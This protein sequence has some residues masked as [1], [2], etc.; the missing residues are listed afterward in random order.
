MP[1]ATFWLSGRGLLS[2]ANAEPET[3]SDVQEADAP[4]I[5]DTSVHVHEWPFR[6]LKYSRTPTLVAKL[7]NHRIQQAWTG[8]FEALLHKNLNEV[9]ARLVEQCRNHGEG[10]LVPFGS[11]NPAWPDWEE[12][13]RR[14]HE[15]YQMPGIRLYPSYHGYTF[16]HRNFTKLIR[17][18]AE[19]GLL[20]QIVLKMEDDRVHHT[21]MDILPLKIQPLIVVLEEIPLA[22][23]Q[24]INCDTALRGGNGLAFIKKTRAVFDIS[25]I[26]GTGGLGRLIEGNHWFYPVTVPVERLLFGSHAP[27]FPC[28]NAVL[29]LFSSPLSLEQLQSLMHRNAKQLLNQSPA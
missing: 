7:R 4:G 1:A 5:I 9:N 23:V 16:D 14:C 21:A 24:L 17:R 3:K 12:D 25:H 18:A 22:R 29:K 2:A 20:I 27:F 13:L 8:S 26:E 15:D 28:E 6:R 11:V 19:R 10:M